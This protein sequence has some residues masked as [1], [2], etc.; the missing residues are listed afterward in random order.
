[1]LAAVASTDAAAFALC[2][3]AG[4]RAGEL[5]GLQVGNVVLDDIGHPLPGCIVA[6]AAWDAKEGRNLLV[7]GTRGARQSWATAS[8]CARCGTR[9]LRTSSLPAMTS[10][11][12]RMDRS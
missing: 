8:F 11:G 2:G 1:M 10:L 6:E 9:S 7:A 4:L 5:K 3:I 12:Y